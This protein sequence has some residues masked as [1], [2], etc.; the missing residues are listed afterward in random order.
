LGSLELTLIE[1]FAK[2]FERVG[3]ISLLKIQYPAGFRLRAQG[4]TPISKIRLEAVV[5]HIDHVCQLA[6]NARHA[7]IGSDL[8][9]GF[10]KEQ[11][12]SGLES[13]AD[14]QKLANPPSP[15]GLRRTE[16]G[17]CDARELD[18]LL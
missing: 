17:R 12:P 1:R 2:H 14:L 6:G 3:G 8:D 5:N 16:C 11:S 9:R 7:A 15:G 10:G 13:I 4:K 18:P